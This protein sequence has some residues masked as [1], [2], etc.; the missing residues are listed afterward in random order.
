MSEPILRL[1]IELEDIEPRIWRRVDVPTGA[2]LSALHDV[3]QA[4]MRWEHANLW[5]F[6]I[7][8]K[9]YGDPMPGFEIPEKRVF[10]AKGLRLAK[11]I[12]RGID[13][14]SYVYDLGDDWRCSI[15]I[16]N[17]REGDPGTDYPK[18]VDGARSAPPEDV[19]GVPGFLEFLDAVANP[20]HP[21]HRHL[22]SW[23]GGAFDADDIDQR[24]IEFDL[25]M[26]AEFRRRVVVGHRNRALKA[27]H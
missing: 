8:G 18:F 27:R 1:L 5:E 13:R 25:A 9:V 6:R 2:T 21:E 7:G 20:K 15:S 24:E 4:V 22:L 11:L 10:K 14:F 3:I 26:L 12:E 16:E 23:A 17:S 19:G